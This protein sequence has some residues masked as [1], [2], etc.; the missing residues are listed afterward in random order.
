MERYQRHA[1]ARDIY[2]EL[3]RGEPNDLSLLL[4][5][6]KSENNLGMHKSAFA[7]LEKIRREL[8]SDAE[9]LEQWAD[10]LSG[11]GRAEE[12]AQAYTGVLENSKPGSGVRLRSAV[13]L[14]MIYSDAGRLDDMITLLQAE[15]H[16]DSQNPLIHRA[17]GEMLEKHGFEREAAMCLNNELNLQRRLAEGDPNNLEA[18]IRVGVL[19]NK[20]GRPRE[21]LRNLESVLARDQAR[22]E[23]HEHMGDAH[24]ALSE[25]DSAVEHYRQAIK[26]SWGRQASFHFKL[27]QALKANGAVQEAI[28]AVLESQRLAKDY[29]PN[30]ALLIELLQ[31]AGRMDEAR[32][33]MLMAREIESLGSAGSA[34]SETR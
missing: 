14:A 4:R 13:K 3:L 26:R 25:Y 6:A 2:S 32:D 15:L 27:A 9:F 8:G 23:I 17:M 24:A 10:A 18:Q 31:S 22:W 21:A 16:N 12:A 28:D 7:R 5:I 20:M 33:Y 30:Y 34:V 11:L 19:E 1:Q 29:L